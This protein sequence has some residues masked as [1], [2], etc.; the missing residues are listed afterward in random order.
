M[1][2]IL[3]LDIASVTLFLNLYK[4]IGEI[5]SVYRSGTLNTNTVNSKF[6]LIQ[7]FSQIVFGTLLSFYVL[8]AQ[9][10]QIS[11]ISKQNLADEWL[12]IN[13]VQPV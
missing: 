8:N 7:I 9:L 6:H 5:S 3:R 10:I 1:S 2:D 11:L 13:R 12:R 4:T